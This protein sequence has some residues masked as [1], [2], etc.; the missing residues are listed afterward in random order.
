MPGTP[1]LREIDRRRLRR[2]DELLHAAASDALPNMP[3]MP[4]H[5]PSAAVP[6]MSGLSTPG[7]SISALSMADIARA[8]G[9][10]PVSLQALTRRA[11]GCSV[12]ERLRMLRL[13]RAHD[14][15]MRGGSVAD[16]AAVAG[17]SAATNFAT[18]YRRRYGC[19]PRQ[20]ARGRAASPVANVE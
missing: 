19:T 2:L 17:Y 20:A 4:T 8:I 15:L 13:E 11:W 7:L 9:T 3:N 1:A 16:A 10:N 12:F 5:A 14:V 6:C 18:A